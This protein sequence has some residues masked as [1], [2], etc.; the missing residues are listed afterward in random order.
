MMYFF[1]ATAP[2]R[3]RSV[4]FGAYTGD[5]NTDYAELESRLNYK[6][7]VVHKFVGWGDDPFA[8]VNAL[9]D[10]IPLVTL[11]NASTT[12]AQIASGSQDSYIQSLVTKSRTYGKPIYFRVGPEMNGNWTKWAVTSA[13]LADFRAAWSHMACILREAPNIKLVWCPNDSTSSGLVSPS[14]Y[15]PGSAAV[16]II[17]IDSYTWDG[18]ITSFEACVAKAYSLYS[19]LDPSKHV[20][21]CETGCNQTSRQAQWLI[22][23]VKSTKYPKLTGIVYFNAVGNEDWRIAT[24]DATTSLKDA[25]SGS[26]SAPIG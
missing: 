7:G 26:A 18:G 20:W 14:Q 9:G 15:Y 1:L 10:R 21:I 3:Q 24:S 2:T 23:M 16:D 4:V 19:G 13:N 11:E 6:L 12:W 5:G 22:E 8:F 17:G 25:L